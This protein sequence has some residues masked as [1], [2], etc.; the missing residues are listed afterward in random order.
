M[1]DKIKNKNYFNEQLEYVYSSINRY[2]GLLSKV[3]EA[4]GE[5]SEGANNGYAILSMFYTQALNLL[6]SAGKEIQEMKGDF[7]NFIKY[8][9]LSW[10]IDNGY[11]DLIRTLSLGVLLNIDTSEFKNLKKK[12]INEGLD[13]YLVNFLLSYIDPSWQF[14]SNDFYFKGIYEPVKNIIEEDNRYISIELLKVYL[15]KQWYDIHNECAWYNSHKSKQDTYYG[16]W[17]YEA[18]A[19]AKILELNDEELKDQQYYPYDLA[20]FNS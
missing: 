19:I 7:N 20:H 6:Y 13:D 9:T 2:E 16:Y 5:Y 3:I 18:G 11:I 12:I 4:H 14:N 1:R 8:Y 10:S 15:E 17:A